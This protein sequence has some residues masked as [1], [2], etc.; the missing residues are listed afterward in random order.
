MTEPNDGL[1]PAPTAEAA[2]AAEPTPAP[3]GSPTTTM[4]IGLGSSRGRWLL[5][6]AVAGG[7]LAVAIV[8]ALLLGG[9][10]TPE[11]LTYIPG[12]S[13]VVAELRMDLPG[14]QLQKVG[15]LLAHFPGFKDQSTLT[16]KIDET[17][18]RLVGEASNGKIDYATQ[19][20]PWL[21]GPLF[22]GG[23]PSP[24]ATTGTESRA[25]EPFVIVATTDGSV[26]CDPLF[27]DASPTSETYQ[28]AKLETA[29]DGS[30]AC[31]IDKRFGL[32][33]LPAT[34]RPRSTPTPRIPGWTREPSTRRPATRSAATAWRRSISRRRR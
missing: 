2:P 5:A 12:D 9:R 16:T 28:G 19:V 30:F 4:P 10:P 29:A 21:A 20:Q 6:L 22:A 8:A 13:A 14:D 32:L 17:L 7:A 27:K 25:R 11:A 26:T 15:N 24:G 31:A 1:Q 34:V 3:G 23:T 33:G 18:A